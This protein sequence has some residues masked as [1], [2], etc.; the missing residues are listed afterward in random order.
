MKLTLRTVFTIISAATLSAGQT[1]AA[2]S[3]PPA[4]LP[5]QDSVAPPRAHTPANPPAVV[6]VPGEVPDPAAKAETARP[7]ETKGK[8]RHAESAPDEP[9]PALKPYVIGAL[10]VLSI[11]VWNDAKLSGFFD[12]R[13]DGMISMQLI[14]EMKADGLTVSELTDVI[15]KKLNASVMEDPEVNV[16]VAKINSKKYYIYGGCSRQGEFP[17]TGEMTVMDAFANCGGFKDFANP[18]KIYILRGTE[19]LPFNYKD[20]SHGKHMEQNRRLQNGD[21]IFVPE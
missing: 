2:Q 21:R 4:T 18:K 3:P 17:L 10:D 12:V 19:Q 20:V 6:P 1:G 8:A 16:Q 15:K 7:K 5:V 14:G 11:T 13:P 9:N